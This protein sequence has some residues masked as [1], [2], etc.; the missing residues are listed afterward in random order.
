MKI[1]RIIISIFLLVFTHGCSSNNHE[2]QSAIKGDLK[3][4]LTLG[5][6]IDGPANIRDSIN[7]KVIFELNDNVLV[8]CSQLKNNWYQ[9]GA[10]VNLKKEQSVDGILKKGIEIFDT[11]GNLIGV[12]K[13]EIDSWIIS[14]KDGVNHGFIGGFTFR[15]NIKPNSIA[16]IELE[17]ILNS[18][19]HLKLEI[20]RDYLDEFQFREGGLEVKGY[21]GLEQFFIY[22]SWIDD[23]SPI[24]RIR[25]MFS[26]NSL[27]AIIHEREL[28]MKNKKSIPLIRD[29]QILIIGDFGS[30]ELK[31]FI[32]SNIASYNGVD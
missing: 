13:D 23:P 29:L 20:F 5:E 31:T 4:E 17:K 8:E 18:K 6:R 22:G 27:V 32:E 25:L 24:D 21:E 11:D 16:E 30:E 19:N 1:S 7:G 2:N 3:S 10:F 28:K 9:V 14:E 12:T 26:N 15:K